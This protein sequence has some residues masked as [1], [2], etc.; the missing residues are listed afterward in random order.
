MCGMWVACGERCA[1]DHPMDERLP[2]QLR[3]RTRRDYARM[4]RTGA[5]A[6]GKWLTVL[7]RYARPGAGRFGLT[8]SRKVGNAVA[9]N[10]VKRRLRHLMRTTFRG[11]FASRDLVIIVRPG[12]A[13]LSFAE[14]TAALQEALDLTDGALRAHRS[15]RKKGGKRRGQ[16][17]AKS[18]K[19][20]PT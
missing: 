17:K 18:D 13:E 1:K 2:R 12:A 8:V 9:R 7:A 3:L 10:L 5:R 20:P 14:L 16:A 4:Q 15:R 6:A 19:P 11:A